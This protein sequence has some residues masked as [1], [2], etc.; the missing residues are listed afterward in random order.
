[1][2]VAWGVNVAGL[3]RPNI[4]LPLLRSLGVD[5]QCLRV[6]RSGYPQHPLM[7][8]SSC[9]MQP[10]TPEAIQEAMTP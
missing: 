8:P 3:E 7:L 9:T 5:P 10:F 1:M 4:V 2:C 6:T